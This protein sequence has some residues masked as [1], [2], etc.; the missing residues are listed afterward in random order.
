MTMHLYH[1]HEEYFL[2][3]T[4]KRNQNPPEL[5]SQHAWWV[6]VLMVSSAFLQQRY[7]FLRCGLE[8][9]K[10]KA[11]TLRLNT[12]DSL[13][14]INIS[15]RFLL[16]FQYPCASLIVSSR[17]LLTQTLNCLP[18]PVPHRYPLVLGT[19]SLMKLSDCY[20]SELRNSFLGTREGKAQC[21]QQAKKLQDPSK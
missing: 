7:L 2:R 14:S 15:R 19:E 9:Y 20:P 10:V 5:K 4:T 1:S 13:T 8:K 3:Q 6:L 16:N 17:H 11:I 21:Q 12:I 18:Q